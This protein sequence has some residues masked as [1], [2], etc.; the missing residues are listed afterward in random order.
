ML[1][2][3]MV[4]ALRKG[5]EGCFTCGDKNHFKRDCLKKVKNLQKSALA[6]V[7]ECIGPKIVNPNLTLKG[8]LF[9]GNSKQGTLQV[10]FNKNQG[11]NSIFSL[12]PST[13][14]RT[15]V[16]IPARNAFLLYPQAVPSRI[17]TGLFGPLPPTNLWSVTW[18][19]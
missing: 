17:P 19:I 7:E 11:Q 8:N 1:A 9:R 2:E 6:A 5:N 10:P 14:G 18:P 16:D 4:A 3:T 12:K 13:A 15:A